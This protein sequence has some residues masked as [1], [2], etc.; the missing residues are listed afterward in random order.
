MRRSL[1]CLAAL[2]T[3]ALTQGLASFASAQINPFKRH[4]TTSLT[5]EDLQLMSAAASKLH[6]SEAPI[7]QAEHGRIRTAAAPGR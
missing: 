7:G 4:N 1:S 3:F 5:Q 6:E 2:L